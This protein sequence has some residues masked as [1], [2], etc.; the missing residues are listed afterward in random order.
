MSPRAFLF[1]AVLSAPV[2][3]LGTV[4]LKNG[5]SLQGDVLAEKVDRVVVDLG[6]TVVTVPRDEIE[7]IT[8]RD[9]APSVGKP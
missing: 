8:A 4:Q 9:A 3:A 6:F 1:F 5:S 7:R 2:F